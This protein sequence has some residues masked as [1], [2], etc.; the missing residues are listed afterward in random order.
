MHLIHVCALPLFEP[1]SF[2]ELLPGF[3][4]PFLRV[5]LEQRSDCDV[6]KFTN[7]MLTGS[8]IFQHQPHC[9]QLH[10]FVKHRQG[11]LGVS[12]SK[13]IVVFLNIFPASLELGLVST[14]LPFRPEDE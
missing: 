7:D 11:A 4:F 5:V 12:I 1:Q 13:S 3:L 14:T 2:T 9:R 8:C 6:F 10:E